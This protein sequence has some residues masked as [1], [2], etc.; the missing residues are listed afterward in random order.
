MFTPRQGRGPWPA[1]A[2]KTPPETGGEGIGQEQE[3]QKR[4]N[5]R[6]EIPEL[7]QRRTLP[8]GSEIEEFPATGGRS[9]LAEFLL[10]S[11]IKSPFCMG[12]GRE[13]SKRD[14]MDARLDATAHH[15]P[16]LQLHGRPVMPRGH[17]LPS[18]FQARFGPR[19]L[20]QQDPRSLGGEGVCPAPIIESQIQGQLRALQFRAQPKTGGS[21][22]PISQRTSVCTKSPY[23]GHVRTRSE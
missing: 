7:G 22:W 3:N 10:A 9:R 8:G 1:D 21:G 5:P 16:F 20:C 6:T 23:S 17:T 14:H 2:R 13:W 15:H 12:A 18:Q 11:G 19:P 4:Q